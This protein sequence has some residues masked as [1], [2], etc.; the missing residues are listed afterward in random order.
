MA[1]G[2]E[3]GVGVDAPPVV[4]GPKVLAIPDKFQDGDVEL[5]LE[6]FSFVC[7]RQ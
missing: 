5:W 2:A 3:G 6:G 7:S 4:P 1:D